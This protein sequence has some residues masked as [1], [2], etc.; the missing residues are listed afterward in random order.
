LDR[1]PLKYAGLSYAEIWISEAQERMVLAVPQENVEA[2]LKLF[3]GE[4]VEATVI[5]TYGTDDTTLQLYYGEMQV[6]ELEMAF[7]HEGLPRPHKDALWDP[8]ASPTSAPP[9]KDDYSR[10]LLELLAS[11]NIAS[12][13]WIIRQYDH[14]VQGGSVVKPLLGASADGPSDAAVVKPKLDTNRGVALACGMNPAL[15]DLDPYHSALHAID[16]ALRNIVCVGGDLER[17]A[18]LDNFCWGNCN[19]PDRMGAL[20]QAAKAC[21][22]GATVYGTPFVSGKD[23]LNN[24]FQTDDGQR[25]A[26]PPT[27]LVSA[28]SIIPDVNW[29]VTA[30]AKA[31]G[32]VLVLVG[33]TQGQLG[34]SHVL[35]VEG[36]QSGNDVPPVDPA[37]N[38][39]TMK[40]VQRVLAAGFARACHDL[41]EG[42]LAVAAA[43]LAFC[44]G[45]GVEI[46][47]SKLPVTAD[48]PD[49]QTGH[50]CLA[51]LFGESAGRFLLEVEPD[52][53]RDAVETLGDVPSA[54]VG[55]VTD[56]GRV[57]IGGFI[58]VSI[59]EAKAA[60][61]G[62]FDW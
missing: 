10:T 23:S 45:L 41:S 2:L 59:A 40:A 38:R 36:L 37:A 30:D 28:I 46:D 34:G 60:W 52:K 51:R 17:T 7:L 33:V 50:A 15:G 13:E 4:D 31:A 6:G 61:Q 47:P 24:E 8:K 18:V 55:T 26:I 58:D 57:K 48:F 53:L 56:S 62:T 14:E 1:V 32:N 27:L 19:K 11:P 25:I 29:C 21:Y 42:G 22:D 35:K 20:V 49:G 16:E 9:A 3:A 44:G 5:G 39:E 12:K 43:E 54:E